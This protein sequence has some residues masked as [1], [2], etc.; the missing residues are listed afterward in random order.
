[1]LLAARTSPERP[2]NQQ[3]EQNPT[4]GVAGSYELTVTGAN[5][6]T[7]SATATVTQDDRSWCHRTRRNPQLR[8]Q[9]HQLTGTGNSTRLERPKQLQQHRTETDGDEAG[10]YWW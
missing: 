5:G 10:T 3:H 9:Q 2:N 1:M 8:H 6:C 7:S 4:V